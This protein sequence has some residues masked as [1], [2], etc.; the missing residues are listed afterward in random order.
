MP[1]HRAR[2]IK[3]LA[4]ELDRECS[5]WSSLFEKAAASVAG[6]LR[7]VADG[8][9]HSATA[10]RRQGEL[11]EHLKLVAE[12]LG[13]ASMQVQHTRSQAAAL[14]AVHELLTKAEADKQQLSEQLRAAT[15]RAEEL[16]AQARV[17]TARTGE[18]EAEARKRGA[19]PAAAVMASVPMAAAAAAASTAIDEGQV[20]ALRLELQE[21]RVENERLASVAEK[22]MCRRFE[23]MPNPTRIRILALTAASSPSL[24][25]PRPHRRVLAL[26]ATATPKLSESSAPAGACLCLSGGL[27]A[28]DAHLSPSPCS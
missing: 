7:V 2:S 5:Q 27:R 6:L 19:S 24:P 1:L 16:S 14:E 3:L 11:L 21:L 4:E 26:T 28:R 13:A 8:A 23:V 18:L 9:S 25:R 15:A 20:A 12:R 22:E 10:G 17:A